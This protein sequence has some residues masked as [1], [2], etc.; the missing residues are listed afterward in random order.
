[1]GGG[2]GGLGGGWGGGGFLF[3][4]AP[5]P[6][7]GRGKKGK[8]DYIS[9]PSLSQL[10]G[11]KRGKRASEIALIG[12]QPGLVGGEEETLAPALIEHGHISRGGSSC[13]IGEHKERKGE[14]KSVRS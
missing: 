2:G 11:E 6:Y 10:T 8:L 13:P 12:L 3:G 7:L 14:G 4:G 9:Q 5:P 1:V